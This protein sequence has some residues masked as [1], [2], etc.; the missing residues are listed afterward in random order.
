MIDEIGGQTI[1]YTFLVFP[2]IVTL[3]ISLEAFIFTLNHHGNINVNDKR[4]KH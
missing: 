4:W 3:Q 1:H 2:M